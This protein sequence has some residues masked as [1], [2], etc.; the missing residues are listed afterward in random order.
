MYTLSGAP[1]NL[2][3]SVCARMTAAVICAIHETIDQGLLSA[4]RCADGHEVEHE[5]DA[6]VELERVADAMCLMRAVC[7]P[8]G[9]R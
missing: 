4:P 2:K 1:V 6:V 7:I 5:V 8:L 9:C 3:Y